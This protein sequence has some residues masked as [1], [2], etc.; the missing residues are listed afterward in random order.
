MSKKSGMII[1][2]LSV[3]VTWLVKEVQGVLNFSLGGLDMGLP[4]TFYKC[5][6]I[7]SCSI[8]YVML[9]V[10]IVFWFVVIWFTW[11][12]VIKRVHRMIMMTGKS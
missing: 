4:L 2:V 12:Q 5:S 6:F 8:S 3:V 11:A 1:L 9:L 10:D 7:S